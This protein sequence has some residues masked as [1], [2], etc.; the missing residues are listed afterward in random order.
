MKKFIFFAIS[1]GLF[2]IPFL[3]HATVC[4]SQT[5]NT[6]NSNFGGTRFNVTFTCH[7]G[8][9]NDLIYGKWIAGSGGVTNAYGVNQTI[10]ED[11]VGDLGM[12]PDWSTDNGVTWHTSADMNGISAGTTFITR[13][14]SVGGNDFFGQNIEFYSAGNQNTGFAGVSGGT[15]YY[16]LGTT[17]CDVISC[18]GGSTSV[19][20]L[21]PA[22]NSTTPPFS[23][24]LFSI[25]GISATNTYSMSV[26]YT[27]GTEC[28]TGTAITWQDILYPTGGTC[29]GLT[30]PG[31]QYYGGVF[32]DSISSFY[33]NT[34]GTVPIARPDRD[35]N[36]A[37]NGADRDTWNAA[38]YLT[39]D[40]LGGQLVATSS[41]SFTMLRYA[42]KY[43][44]LGA[45]NGTTTY[46]LPS[47]VGGMLTVTSTQNSFSTQY[48]ANTSS[49]CPNDT[50][51]FCTLT[52]FIFTPHTSYSNA[53]QEQLAITKTR[54]PINMVYTFVDTASSSLVNGT[55]TYGSMSLTFPA[56][57]GKPSSSIEI[58]N[59]H[60]LDTAGVPA[61][62]KNTY[63]TLTRNILWFS[64]AIG[65]ITIPFL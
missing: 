27:R 26:H 30:S 55:N 2:F 54:F 61:D 42:G 1:F 37:Q 15:S 45:V 22:N 56:L 41:I 46:Y 33:G 25:S 53:L 36:Y 23:P 8:T 48:G 5:T 59:N 21:Y 44:V 49:T 10:R 40:T 52:N 7:T 13:S 19:S 14:E 34:T 12:A 38:V 47:Y 50:F 6:G 4:G 11:T 51:G 65:V 3:S 62:I 9:P 24:W 18:G 17:L 28:I 39:N 35:L 20:F 29:G 58:I 32:S 31:V 64:T 63:F 60:M 43:D 57:L 16:I